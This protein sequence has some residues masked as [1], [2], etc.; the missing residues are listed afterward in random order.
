MHPEHRT[1]IGDDRRT[2]PRQRT[3]QGCGDLGGAGGVVDVVDSQCGATLPHHGEHL[4]D[5]CHGRLR[6][7]AYSLSQ[8]QLAVIDAQQWFER[9]RGTQPGRSGPDPAAAAQVLQTLHHQEGMH[10]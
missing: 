4:F 7:G 10:P 1:E 3:G 5:H 8:H 2:A 9:Q 6:G